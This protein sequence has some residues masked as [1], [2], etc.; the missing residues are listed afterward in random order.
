MIKQ[1]TQIYFPYK[2]E[3]TIQTLR[4]AEHGSTACPLNPGWQVRQMIEFRLALV[5]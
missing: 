4:C 1:H 2:E 5:S 3:E